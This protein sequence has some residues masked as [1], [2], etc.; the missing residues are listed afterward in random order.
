MGAKVITRGSAQSCGRARGTV[1]VLVQMADYRQITEWG[2]NSGYGWRVSTSS[3]FVRARPRQRWRVAVPS[4]ALTLLAALAFAAPAQAVRSYTLDIKAHWSAFKAGSEVDVP[5]YLVENR[6]PDVDTSVFADTT[7]RSVEADFG[8]VHSKFI[9]FTPVGGFDKRGAGFYNNLVNQVGN[10]SGLHLLLVSTAGVPVTVDASGITGR[11]EVQVGTMRVLVGP[12]FELADGRKVVFDAV[13]HDF[14]SAPTPIAAVYTGPGSQKNLTSMAT[15]GIRVFVDDT[16]PPGGIAP[17]D[18]GT[19]APPAP[20]APAPPPTPPAAP[21]VSSIQATGKLK[22][23]ATAS[24]SPFTVAK[25]APKSGTPAITLTL[26]QPVELTATLARRKARSKTV[27][28]PM[29]G[30]ATV[31][32]GATTIQLKL[33]GSWKGKRLAVGYYRLTFTTPSGTSQSVDF[34]VR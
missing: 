21:G 6:A 33:T 34:R 12:A 14:P 17:G 13:F 3:S 8:S 19:P 23:P 4:A 24:K 10:K 7:L 2:T 27:Y 11:T 30:K 25:K 9:S 28:T 15:R 1:G 31:P 22:R 29:A 32:K 16:L 18:G 20:N 5:V 26:T